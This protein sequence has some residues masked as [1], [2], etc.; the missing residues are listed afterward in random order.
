M[1]YIWTLVVPLAVMD[2]CRSVGSIN[3]SLVTPVTDKGKVMVVSDIYFNVAM[4]LSKWKRH[5]IIRERALK[6]AKYM[7]KHLP[8]FAKIRT[9]NLDHY[10]ER[11]YAL[12]CP[13]IFLFLSLIKVEF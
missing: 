7:E 3:C 8:S 13:A 5:Q 6:I 12:D 2:A 10:P 9:P 11:T 4:I 1:F